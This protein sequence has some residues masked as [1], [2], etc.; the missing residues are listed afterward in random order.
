[1]KVFL[2][3]SGI[4]S[5]AVALTLREWLP[6]ILQSV[7]PWM[8]DT[9]IR[10]GSRWSTEVGRQLQHAG[11]GIICLTQDNAAAPWIL[12]EAGALA[13]SF[14]EGAVCPYLLD[15]PYKDLSGP[16]AQFQGK[17]A[18]EQGTYE[19]IA[20]IN[21]RA[22]VRLA[23]DRLDK[24][25]GKVWPEIERAL[26][27]IP[28][29]IEITKPSRPDPDVLEEL[30][31]IVRRMERRL[32]GPVETQQ[33]GATTSPDL[34][35]LFQA[36]TQIDISVLRKH[37]EAAAAK[38][39]AAGLADQIGISERALN[40]F[41]R[42]ERPRRPSDELQ[43]RRWFANEVIEGRLLDWYVWPPEPEV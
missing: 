41:L 32:D 4:R 14:E 1:V 11:F 29:S 34:N 31:T 3:W 39:P 38:L 16:L 30:V 21:E 9:D 7:E 8:S 13:Q 27:G 35:Q 22:D 19:V 2:S 40:A 26:S 17:K 23:P 18:D 20:A 15:L 24:I 12:F 37:V 25:F 36:A 5:R 6:V 33:T 10:A 43:V 42:N 28:P